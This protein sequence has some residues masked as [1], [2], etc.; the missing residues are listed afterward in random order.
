MDE[1]NFPFHLELPVQKNLW[2]YPLHVSFRTNKVETNYT[3][4]NK[5]R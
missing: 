5:V 1:K 4:Y 2:I 3:I